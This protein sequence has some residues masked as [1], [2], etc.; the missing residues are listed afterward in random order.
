MI[1]L[2]LWSRAMEPQGTVSQQSK[3]KFLLFKTAPPAVAV[4]V[5]VQKRPQM[6]LSEWAWWF[7]CGRADWD[8]A[9]K[10]KKLLL[11]CTRSCRPVC[12]LAFLKRH[13]ELKSR[14]SC[15]RCSTFLTRVSLT[16]DQDVVWRPLSGSGGAQL[17][18]LCCRCFACFP[19][20]KAHCSGCG[21]AALEHSFMS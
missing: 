2:V 15:R 18:A 1:S 6:P 8:F 17:V 16:F 12:Y 21:E 3:Q 13:T 5:N 10:I 9:N 19:F 4:V 11:F 14:F 20:K 7:P